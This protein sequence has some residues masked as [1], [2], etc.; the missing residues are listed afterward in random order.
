MACERG[1]PKTSA[2]TR[3][4]CLKGG[5]SLPCSEEE[6]VR[7]HRYHVFDEPRYCQLLSGQLV[8]KAVLLETYICSEK[9]EL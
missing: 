1:A 9:A 3:A 5:G 6:G 7:D 2:W 8:N 4:T